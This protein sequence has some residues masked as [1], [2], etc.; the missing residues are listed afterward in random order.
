MRSTTRRTREPGDAG[1]GLDR[2]IGTQQRGGPR[3]MRPRRR[4]AR[5][6]EEHRTICEPRSSSLGADPDADEVAFADDAGFADRSHSTEERSRSIS[7]GAEPCGRTCATSTGRS[8]RS[9]P[10][11]TGGASGAG[12]R[13]P[14]SA[15][16]R[17]R[18]RRCASGASRQGAAR[19]RSR[20]RAGR[21]DALVPRV[22]VVVC[23]SWG[24][25]EAPDAAEYG[26]EGSE[27]AGQH[28][29][30]RG[31]PRCPGPGVARPRSAHRDRRGRPEGR[32]AAPR[33]DG[34]SSAPRA[35]TRPRAT[36]R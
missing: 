28:R 13:S 35:R 15:S 8:R 10:A 31:G 36:G 1:R 5:S 20:R 29:P 34:R 6:L 3:W 33:T 21:P 12:S 14:P 27:H 24:V 22:L 18:G 17:C 19:E 30:R 32:A 11:R 16:T 25:G 7:G 26:D 2:G 4:A 9:R 23:D